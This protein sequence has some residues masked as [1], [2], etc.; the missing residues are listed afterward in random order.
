[1]PLFQFMWFLMTS[2]FGTL[3]RRVKMLHTKA[4]QAWEFILVLTS[5]REQP[6]TIEPSAKLFI[7]F[8]IKSALPL[9]KV[10][11]PIV[12]LCLKLGNSNTAK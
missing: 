4:S 11:K 8:V 5:S 9:E 3:F 1:M 10:W 6:I 2:H 12:C 7:Q